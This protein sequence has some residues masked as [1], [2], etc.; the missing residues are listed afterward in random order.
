MKIYNRARLNEAERAQVECVRNK[1]GKAVDPNTG[2]ILEEG[3]IDIGHK[4]G[5]EEHAMQE[6]ARR[7]GMSQKDYTRM[8][9]NPKLYQLEDRHENRSRLHECK[10]PKE[11]RH[12]CMQVIR[13][14]KNKDNGKSLLSARERNALVQEKPQQKS[15]SSRSKSSIASKSVSNAGKLGHSGNGKGSASTGKSTGNSGGSGKGTSAGGK[16]K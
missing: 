1:D 7:C 12:K 10:N 11:Q 2:K 8:M 3:K 16:G 15:Q 14:F 13:E 4:Y 6:C 9:K 5:Y